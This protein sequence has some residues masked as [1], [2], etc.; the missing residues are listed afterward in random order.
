MTRHITGLFAVGLCAISLACSKSANDKDTTPTPNPVNSTGKASIWV[1]TGDQQRLLN[2]GTDIDI[3]KP[4]AN[5]PAV[6]T[7]DFSQT[8]QEIDGFGAALTGSSAYLINKKLNPSQRDQL[9]RDLFDPNTGIGIS[10]L[11]T[12]IGASDFSLSDYTYNDLPAGQTD[13]Q[14]QKFS[15]DKEKEDVIPVFKAILAIAPGIKIMATPWSA[16]AW[17][18][19]NGLLGRGKLKPEWYPTYA[20]Y[21][22]KYLQAIKA[23]GIS[24]ETLSV[25]NEPLHEATYPSMRMEATEQLDFIK[26]HL[27]P[28]FRQQGVTTK[29]LLYDHNWDRPDYPLTILN[30]PQAKTFVAGSAF[31]AYGGNVS[32]MSQVHNAHPDKGLY[33]TEISGGAWATNFSDNMKWNM[34]N[35]FIGTTR[36]WSRNALLWN[37]ALDENSGPTNR[38]CNNCRGVVTIQASGNIVR[39]V[40]YYT[41][42]HMSR[43]IR[44]GAFRVSSTATGLQDVESVAFKNTNGAKVLVLLNGSTDRKAITVQTNDQ[45]FICSLEGNA[46]ATIVW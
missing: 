8:L 18:K 38:G 30:D 31:H 36:N 12:T 32:A 2:K 13:P 25:Q 22:L 27:G 3:T 14:L 1:T 9:L 40:E 6:I 21:L 20:N 29:L 43:F 45:Q 26:N 16:P 23:E 17:M 33:F 35:I 46:V 41:L 11:R 19:T 4:T 28:L 24:I 5:N 10:Y 42:G 34:R 39:N 7:I 15:I 37:L 44:P